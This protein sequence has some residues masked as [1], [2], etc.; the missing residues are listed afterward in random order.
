M[1]GHLR[2][3]PTSSR[4]SARPQYNFLVFST[5]G[6]YGLLTVGRFYSAYITQAG[7]IESRPLFL[8]NFM[9]SNAF[10]TELHHCDTHR[11]SSW[12]PMEICNQPPPAIYHVK[13][14]CLLM[15]PLGPLRHNGLGATA[16]PAPP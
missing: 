1:E 4:E 8:P 7:I 14:Q 12:V 3:K 11:R 9:K 15:W 16:I 10:T 6:K 5:C 13:Y 2:E